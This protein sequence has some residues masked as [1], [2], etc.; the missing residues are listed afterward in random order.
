MTAQSN[1]ARRL[2]FRSRNSRSAGWFAVPWLLV[3]SAG[4]LWPTSRDGHAEFAVQGI[5]RADEHWLAFATPGKLGALHARPGERVAKDS[6]LAALDDGNTHTSVPLTPRARRVAELRSTLKVQTD[7]LAD[8]RLRIAELQS[9]DRN[10]VR[11]VRNGQMITEGAGTAH[12]IHQEILASRLILQEAQM[13]AIRNEIDALEEA[14]VSFPGPFGARFANA[15]ASDS[16][17]RS[18]VDGRVEAVFR[19][20][21]ELATPGEPVLLVTETDPLFVVCTLPEDMIVGLQEGDLAT[22]DLHGIPSQPASIA[23]IGDF[24]D[25]VGR[26]GLSPNHSVRAFRVRVRLNNADGRI[27]PG[28][29]ATV[30]FRW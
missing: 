26:V 12:A 22:V 3:V 15:M 24:G 21:G 7:R 1:P 6:I 25:F 2:W 9:K 4:F 8:L 17:I 10:A 11:R 19:N 27:R 20:A 30:R 16:M 13:Q 28:M 5:V 14:P 29:G 23:S 18:P